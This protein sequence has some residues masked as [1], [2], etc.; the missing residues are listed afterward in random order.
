M[1]HV[2]GHN[3]KVLVSK[4]MSKG[5]KLGTKEAVPM[6]DRNQTVTPGDPMSRAAGQYGKGHSFYA[7]TDPNLGPSMQGPL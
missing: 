4:A 6:G 7:P 1:P 5:T 2:L 3:P